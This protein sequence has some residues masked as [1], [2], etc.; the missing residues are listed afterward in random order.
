MLVATANKENEDQIIL[1]SITTLAN[2][3]SKEIVAN[4]NLPPC[5]KR[6]SDAVIVSLTNDTQNTDLLLGSKES[7]FMAKTG[8]L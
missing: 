2:I 5:A 8:K 6:P 3:N 1:S 4:T 7:G